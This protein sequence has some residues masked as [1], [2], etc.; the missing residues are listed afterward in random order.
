MIF[1]LGNICRDTTFGLERLPSPG[2]TVNASTTYKGLGGKGLN[3][4]VA[5]ANA[6]AATRLIA[7]IGDDWTDEDIALVKQA[8]PNLQLALVAK[9]GHCDSSTVI[10]SRSGENI[11]VTDAAQAEALT[12]AEAAL[13][14]EF[15][16]GDVL[17]LQCN[18]GLETTCAAIREA[19][20]KGVRIILNPAPFKSWARDLANDIDVAILNAQE[21]LAWTGSSPAS[22]AIEA[23]NAPLAIVTLGAGG[24]LAQRKG[25]TALRFSASIAEAVDTTA[26]GDT[27]C[28]VFAAEWLA[29][30]NERQAIRLAMSS[31]AMSV[32][33]QGAMASVPSR[34]DID[35]LRR[36]AG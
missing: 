13:H 26:A 15:S 6:G 2:E 36:L 32:T 21:A 3:Q 16:A 24:C 33:K 19:R 17:L 18:L 22:V 30:G 1:V 11:I 5:A 29:T 27:F 25:H 8:A 14:F 7:G 28:G 10:V 4:A 20:R 12:P 23:L 9:P 35:R 34:R 31:A